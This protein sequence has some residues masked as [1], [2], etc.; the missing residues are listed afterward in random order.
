MRFANLYVRT[1]V[2]ASLILAASA[3]QTAQSLSPLA[4]STA[5]L[6]PLNSGNRSGRAKAQ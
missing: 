3:C 5:R 4:I 6:K 2:L 1:V